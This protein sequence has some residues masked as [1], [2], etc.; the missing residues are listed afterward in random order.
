MTTLIEQSVTLLESVPDSQWHA[1]QAQHH[2]RQAQTSSIAADH[3]EDRG[4]HKMAMLHH[5]L[6]STHHAM[7]SEHAEKAGL[8]SKAMDHS[9]GS[10]H[11][12]EEAE[13]LRTTHGIKI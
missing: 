5:Q 8:K 12:H 6:A 13:R 2:S 4:E 7:A 10:L 9:Y 11:H 1:M 3:H